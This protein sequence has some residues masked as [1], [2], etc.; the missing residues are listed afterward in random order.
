M[1][2]QT[3]TRPARISQKRLREEFGGRMPFS[4]VKPKPQQKEAVRQIADRTGQH[5][6]GFRE[7][8]SPEEMKI[9]VERKRR[10]QKGKCGICGLRLLR[11][12]ATPDHV[13]PRRMGGGFRDDH[14]DNIQ[15]VHGWCNQEKGSKRNFKL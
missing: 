4:T 14:P 12:Q 13:E 2:I 11:G 9:L 10:E 15:A 3:Y 5:P 8:R 6:R 1:R 7:I